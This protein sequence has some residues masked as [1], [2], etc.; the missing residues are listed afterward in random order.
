[1]FAGSRRTVRRR[2]SLSAVLQKV[3]S[4]RQPAGRDVGIEIIRRPADHL[5]R[6]LGDPLLLHQVF[7]NMLLNAEQA[8][9]GT[10]RPGQI[11]VTT[12]AVE[13][14]VIVTI[15]DT[16]PGI[17]PEALQRIFEPFYTTKEV[18]QGT[19]LGLAIAYGIIQDHGGRI[20]AANHP[21]GGAVLTVT[22]PAAP[23]RPADLT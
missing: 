14:Q 7:L 6:V 16:G 4:L 12:S 17:P 13:G 23:P 15:R 22:L 8:I 5:P 2:V 18:G 20:T 21:D 1:M 19:G 11:E 3:I 9:A 10:T